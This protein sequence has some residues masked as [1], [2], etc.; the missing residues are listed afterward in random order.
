[1]KP[2]TLAAALAVL[3]SSAA[4]ETMRVATFNAS[5][6]RA[7]EGEL[8]A[9]IAAGD[10]PQMRDVAAIIAD[11]NP[12]LIL[13]NEFDYAEGQGDAFVA[14]YLDGAYPHVFI[15]PSNTGVPSGLDLDGSGQ[16]VTEPGSPAYGN[17]AYGFGFF[18]GQYGMVVLSKYDILQD[19]VRTFQTFKWADMPDARRPMNP[20]GTPFHSDEIWAQLRLSSKSHWDVPVQVGDQ[21]VHFLVSHPTPPVFDGPED[22]NGTRNADEIRFWADYIQGRDYMVDDAGV[23]GGLAQGALFVI[24]G[25]MNADPNDGD[26][27]DDAAMQLLSLD[28]INTS[29]IPASDGAASVAQD[30][31]NAAH[32]GAPE[33]DTADWNDDG[34]GNLR[35]DYV[36]PSAQMQIT[37]AGVYWPRPDAPGAGRIGVSD[38]RLVWIDLSLN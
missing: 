28:L 15:A 29:R 16:A 18:P 26:S 33:H 30:G 17:D 34:P 10:N 19:Q 25:D 2:L 35:V 27:T 24:A 1:M 21:V 4:A 22:R 5:L 37:D 3:T 9:D 14:A 12:D 23:K 20:D 38:H 8:A 32:K 13:I 6:N 11:V 7:A 36:L 31:A